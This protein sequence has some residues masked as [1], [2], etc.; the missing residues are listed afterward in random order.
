MLGFS[1]YLS[2]PI[3]EKVQARIE[4]FAK[5]G[6]TGVFTSL[7]LPEDD[8]AVLLDR[9]AALGQQCQSLNLELTV[10]ISTRAQK[11]TGL[12]LTQPE[13]IAELGVARLRMDEGIS[14]KEIADLSQSIG[15]ALN[16]STLSD[17]DV[18]TLQADQ[19]NFANIEAWHNYYPRKN[20]GLGE[21]WFQERNI[22]LHEHGI[23]VTAFVPGDRGLRGPVYAGLPSLESA[24]YQHPLAAALDLQQL[25]VDQIDIGDQNLLQDTLAQFDAYFDHSV[26]LLHLLTNSTL[27]KY[28]QDGNLYLHQR[29]DVARDVVRLVEGRALNQE[30]IEPANILPRKR[31]AVTLDNKLALRYQGELEIVKRDLPADPTVNVL[32]YIQANELDLLEHCGPGQAIQLVF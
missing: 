26:L 7:N 25:D 6:F 13:K 15:I 8:P 16:A 1:V 4:R 9:L 21:E 17:E 24:R 22:W 10:D 31:G 2:S 18:Q 20:T 23:Q 30:T 27:P 5:S 32:G 19:A 14:M 11:R 3:T 12:N 28:M 29:P